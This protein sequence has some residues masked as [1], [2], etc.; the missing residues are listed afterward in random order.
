MLFYGVVLLLLATP[1]SFCH[2]PASFSHSIRHTGRFRFGHEALIESVV[3]VFGPKAGQV[4]KN[5]IE[6]SFGPYKA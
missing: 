5:T 6:L 1:V 4:A 2:F 3:T